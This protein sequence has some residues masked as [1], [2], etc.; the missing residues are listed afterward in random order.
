M[1]AASAD[2]LIDATT[3]EFQGVTLGKK[4]TQVVIY[5]KQR[6][7]ALLPYPLNPCMVG[8][9]QTNQMQGPRTPKGGCTGVLVL[10]GGR[11]SAA[12]GKFWAK[13]RILERIASGA[14]SFRR[15]K[16]F[17]GGHFQSES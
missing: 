5:P 14:S 11:I 16:N 7:S 3:I 2:F 8:T 13:I 6:R 4:G 15:R 12:G 10:R 9:N 17:S 1:E